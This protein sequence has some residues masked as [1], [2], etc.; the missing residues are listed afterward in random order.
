M[1]CL[2][3]SEFH[4]PP[5]RLSIAGNPKGK[6]VGRFFF[7]SVSFVRTK[8]MNSPMKGEKHGSTQEFE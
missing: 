4:I 5:A 2:S 7:G 3:D 6:H 8:E 1:C